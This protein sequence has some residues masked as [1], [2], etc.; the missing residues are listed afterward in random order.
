MST[1]HLSP[2]RATCKENLHDDDRFPRLTCIDTPPRTLDE[3]IDGEPYLI[4]VTM[5]G[6]K[7]LAAV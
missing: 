6:A 2:R 4:G 3:E 5:D 1:S 7:I